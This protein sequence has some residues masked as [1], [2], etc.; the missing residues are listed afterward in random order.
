[1]VKKIHELQST[2]AKPWKDS[3]SME[4]FKKSSGK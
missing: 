4:I 2:Y 3:R 1:M